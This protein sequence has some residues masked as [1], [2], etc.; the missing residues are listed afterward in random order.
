MTRALAATLLSLTCCHPRSKRTASMKPPITV[1]DAPANLGLRPP[2]PGVVPGTYRAPAALRAR[3]LI[4]RL[5]ARDGGRVEPPAYSPDPE[6]ETG[7]RNGKSIQTF[8]EAL[9]YRTGEI[10]RIGGRPLV[11]GGD[12]SILIGN[13]LALRTIGRYGL[14]FIDG[15]D[16]YS[17]VRDRAKYRGLFA[18]AGLDLALV[19][20]HGPDA[21]VNRR[22]LKPYVEE[23]DVVLFGFYRDPADGRDYDV[24]AIEASPI[25]QFRIDKLRRDGVRAAAEEARGVIEA[26]GLDGFWIHVDTDVLDLTE[27]PAVDSPN[28]H[29]LTF[30]ELAETLRVFLASPQAVGLEITIY[31]PDLDP[32]GVYGDR[33]ADTIVGALSS[34]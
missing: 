24:D 25:R 15:H 1:L 4:E 33:L 19:T 16:D 29:G 26:R 13:M 9:A 10:V 3:K 7:F 22:G 17:Y 6:H 5:G 31:D 21:L 28:D 11:L 12:C 18:A 14:V 20:G 8:S 30:D 34:W 23:R 32:E 2:R 27:M